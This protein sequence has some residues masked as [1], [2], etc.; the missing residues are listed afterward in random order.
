MKT[1]G[2]TAFAAT[3]RPVNPAASA[4]TSRVRTQATTGQALY[5]P[6]LVPVAASVWYSSL[7]PSRAQ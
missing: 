2:I 5:G 3:C 4:A 7:Q 6:L 1:S